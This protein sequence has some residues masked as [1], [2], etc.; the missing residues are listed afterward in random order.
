MKQSDRSRSMRLSILDPEPRRHGGSDTHETV[1]LVE[2]V[3]IRHEDHEG[4]A[5]SP[6]M[7]HPT[8]RG[9]IRVD[10]RAEA[11]E[12]GADPRHKRVCVSYQ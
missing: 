7:R 11:G 6:A 9:S 4:R 8:R 5:T 1:T 12:G 10:R 2:V 3:P